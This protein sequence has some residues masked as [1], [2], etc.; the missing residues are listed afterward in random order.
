M[1]AA[2]VARRHFGSETAG[3]GARQPPARRAEEWGLVQ[4]GRVGQTNT[5]KPLLPAVSIMCAVP[6]L[7]PSQSAIRACACFAISRFRRYRS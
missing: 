2:V 7:M 1:L 6:L 4:A 3:Q 5:R